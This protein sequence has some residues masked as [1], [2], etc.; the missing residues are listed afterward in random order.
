MATELTETE[1]NRRVGDCCDRE[2]KWA[3]LVDDCVVPMPER[4]V[5][6]SVI[7]EQASIPSGHVLVRD[8]N[9]A[10]D[11]VLTHESKVDLADGNVFY[12]IKACDVQ[13][14]GHC[15]SPAKLAFFVNDRYELTVRADQTGQSIRDLFNLPRNATLVRDDVGRIDEP[16]EPSVPVLFIDGPVFYSRAVA[17]ALSITVNAR[18]FTEH[19]G[20][21]PEMTGRE[22]ASLVYPQSPDETRIW[23]VSGGNREIG[24]DERLEIHGCEVFDVVRKK[25][26]GGFENSRV[27]GEIG[28]LQ[29]TAQKVTFVPS[30]VDAVVYHDVRTRPGSLVAVTDVLVPV[31]VS[32]PGE[33]ID[34][35]Y[36]PDDSPLI[37][38]VKGSPQDHR[39]I[40]LGRTWRRIS[41]HPHNGGGGPA[42]N[43]ALYGF[44]TYAG[45][46]LS[47]LYDVN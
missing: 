4:T 43:P 44:H 47:W 11:V 38:R 19:D 29:A 16:I 1:R 27:E 37:G 28:K 6:V 30:P 23:F 45:E 26:D 39:I 21:K 17:A 5:R 32:Y 31:P 8:H 7:E 36:L 41:Y 10:E 13:P 35:A 34:W 46:L 33:M 9:S 3:A 18:I 22:I 14:R 20:V 24:L 40:A 15:S 25:V 42:W 12:T 2:A